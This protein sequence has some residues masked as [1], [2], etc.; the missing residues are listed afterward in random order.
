MILKS[1]GLMQDR[2]EPA[3]GRCEPGS[4]SVDMAEFSG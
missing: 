2:A 1:C 3:E 4:S